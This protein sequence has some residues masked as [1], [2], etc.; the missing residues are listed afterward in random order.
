M[1]VDCDECCFSGMTYS[2]ANTG[3]DME[4]LAFCETWIAQ[5]D[6][7]RDCRRLVTSRII[8][9]LWF[10]LTLVGDI[11]RLGQGTRE[12]SRASTTDGVHDDMSAL[13][14]R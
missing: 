11:R 4:G 8:K 13:R 1:L 6:D 9:W 10:S 2:A 3:S 14:E 7:G 12:S 5:E